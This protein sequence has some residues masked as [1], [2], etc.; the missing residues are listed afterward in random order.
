MTW[1]GFRPSDDACRYGYHVPSNAFATVALADTAL[2]LR[3]EL[4]AGLRD[5]GVVQA[6]G[7]GRVYA[8]EVD[9]LGN[10]AL[11]DDA[12]IPSL[13]SLPYLGFCGPDDPVYR[14]TRELVLSR[15]NPYYYTGRHAAGVGSAHTEAGWVWH[16]GVAMQ[17][18][19]S[20][21]PDEQDRVLAV[22]EATDGGTGLMH[23]AF[24]PN[25]PTRFTR[26]WFSWANALYSELVL[27]WLGIQVAPRAGTEPAG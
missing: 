19:T 5:W 22:M 7:L 10:S 18:L 17:G 16:L 8:Y 15:T 25:D 3:Q 14:A 11:M 2:T 13:L 12:N 24:D 21:D 4:L 9:G 27:T 23:E 26:P 20:S 6:P 1:C